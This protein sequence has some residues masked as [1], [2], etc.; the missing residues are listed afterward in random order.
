[1]MSATERLGRPV[2]PQH[3]LGVDLVDHGRGCRVGGDE[4]VG[5]LVPS[6]GP[7][8]EAARLVGQTGEAV[9]HHLQVE[10]A[11]QAEHP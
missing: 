7:D 2:H 1:M 6:V 10:D 5:R 9:G 11:G 8:Q 4:E 3:L